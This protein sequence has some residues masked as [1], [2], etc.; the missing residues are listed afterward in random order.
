MLKLPNHL[1]GLFIPGR[2]AIIKANYTLLL[3]N[4]PFKSTFQNFKPSFLRGAWP[5]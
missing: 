1:C 2:L 5:S 3:Q 4:A